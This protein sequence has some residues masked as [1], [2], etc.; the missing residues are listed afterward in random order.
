MLNSKHI[1]DAQWRTNCSLCTIDLFTPS[2]ARTPLPR[3]AHAIPLALGRAGFPNSFLTA[4]D[5]MA[6]K[7]GVKAQLW[8]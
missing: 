2:P 8:N 7:V 6:E 3:I 1:R 4:L 5:R